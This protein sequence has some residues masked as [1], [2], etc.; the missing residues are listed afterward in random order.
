MPELLPPREDDTR[1]GP[2]TAQTPADEDDLHLLG[3]LANGIVI[4]GHRSSQ[5]CAIVSG[6][7]RQ[8]WQTAD[9]THMGQ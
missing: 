5:W 9:G 2:G 3:A 6:V 4:H 8:E 7:Q 1:P